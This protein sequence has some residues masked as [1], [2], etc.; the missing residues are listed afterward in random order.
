MDNIL[1]RIGLNITLLREERGLTQEKLAELAGLHRAYIGQIERG[2]K[3]FGLK[4]LEKIAKALN[5]N[6]RVLVDTSYV[7][8]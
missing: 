4:N 8:S 5:V 7:D 1:D 6:I 3:N 2:E